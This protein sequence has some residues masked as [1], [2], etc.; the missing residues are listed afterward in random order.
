MKT[1]F[2]N[3]IAVLS[4]LFPE[5]VKVNVDRTSIMKE[6]NE[7]AEWEY[8]EYFKIEIC[9]HD[10]DG[11]VNGTSYAQAVNTWSLSGIENFT[12]NR[13]LQCWL[14]WDKGCRNRDL[15]SNRKM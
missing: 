1:G 9:Y 15:C 13:G 8:V 6:M 4:S 2:A 3:E 14:L 10:R 7:W 12:I 11:F 5:I